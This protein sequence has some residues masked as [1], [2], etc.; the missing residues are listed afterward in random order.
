M[1]KGVKIFAIVIGIIAILIFVFSR[2]GSG[3]PASNDGSLTSTVTNNTASST[4]LPGGGGAVVP[5]E[6]TSNFTSLLSS[7]NSINLDTTIFSN[8]AYL[9][10]R[11]NPIDLGT[12]IVGRQNPFAPIGTDVNGSQQTTTLQVQTL[13]PGKVLATSAEFG[14]LITASSL[15]PT[16]VVFQY[17]TSDALGND[18]TPVTVSKNGTALFT[19]TGLT[20]GT[21]YYVEAV[22]VQGSIT[23]TG[24]IMSFTTPG[25]GRQ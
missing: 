19:I 15:S 13:A 18:T 25:T 9:A 17:G 8:P 14:A 7:I 6:T 5:S 22:A 11:N 10:L 21:T 1:S 16:T 20:P 12:A 4:T 23:T 2:V 24:N 3:T